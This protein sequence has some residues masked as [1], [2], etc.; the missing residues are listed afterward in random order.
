LTEDKTGRPGFIHEFNATAKRGVSRLILRLN[1]THEE[2]LRPPT[3]M[4]QL[5]FLRTYKNA[6]VVD[7]LLCG[8]SVID[9]RNEKVQ[10][11]AMWADH[12]TFKFSLPEVYTIEMDAGMYCGPQQRK[13]VGKYATVELVHYSRLAQ[14]SSQQKLARD[15]EKFKLVEVKACAFARGEP[16]RR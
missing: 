12:E 3:R 2:L 1:A 9:G 8:N 6:G 16:G 14:Y 15:N 13:D 5:L 4:L 11:D 10:L 7:L